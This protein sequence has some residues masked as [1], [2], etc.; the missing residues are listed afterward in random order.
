MHIGKADATLGEIFDALQ[1]YLL[2]SVG[3]EFMHIVDTEQRHWIMHSHGVSAF[4]AGFT[5][6]MCALSTVA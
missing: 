6:R 2:Q 4:G 3:A 5:A 1:S